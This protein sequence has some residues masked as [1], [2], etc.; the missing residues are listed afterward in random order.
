MTWFG[1]G[2]SR[3][4]GLNL[5]PL[6]QQSVQ[7]KNMLGKKLLTLILPCSSGHYKGM[8]V[9]KVTLCHPLHMMCRLGYLQ[10]YRRKFRGQEGRFAVVPENA[11][12]L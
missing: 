6:L 2:T 7:K 8:H 10:E 4:H 1:F 3:V 9:V 12:L 11:G 5:I